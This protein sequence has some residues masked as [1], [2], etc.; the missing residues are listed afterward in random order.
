MSDSK[1]NPVKKEGRP[2]KLLSIVNAELKMNGHHRVSKTE[3]LEILSLIF[4]L[5]EAQL[6]ELATQKDTPFD[7]C[8][9]WYKL[10]KQLGECSSLCIT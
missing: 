8:D 6:R 9:I 5:T 3:L 7:I 2:P 1:T 4:N 10:V